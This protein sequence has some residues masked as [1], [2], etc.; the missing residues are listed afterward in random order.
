MKTVA[1]G[2]VLALA[3]VL[4]AGAEDTPMSL[5]TFGNWSAYSY[6]EG[7][8][9]VCFMA[10]KPTKMLPA[11]AKRGDVYAMITHRP[12]ENSTGVFSIVTGYTYKSGSDVQVT[13]GNQKFSLFTQ[14]DTAWTRDEASD[15]ALGAALRSGSNMSVAGTSARGTKTTDSYSLTGSSAAYQAISQKCGLR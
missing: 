2:L 10:T 8:K 1:L 11:G 6:A 15:R 4:P 12:A 9:T 3:A 5:G 7:G 13:V 14:G